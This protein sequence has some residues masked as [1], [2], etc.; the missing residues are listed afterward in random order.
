M[1][2]VLRF[3]KY[4]LLRAVLQ[5]QKQKPQLEWLYCLVACCRHVAFLYLLMKSAMFG[6]VAGLLL[7]LEKSSPAKGPP[8]FLMAISALK[9][10]IFAATSGQVGSLLHSLATALPSVRVAGLN[11]HVPTQRH[12]V[13]NVF[14]A[15]P[16]GKPEKCSDDDDGHHNSNHMFQAGTRLLGLLFVSVESGHGPLLALVNECGR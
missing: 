7:T 8:R 15:F 6:S 9:A 5:G 16:S 1:K 3:C 13:V 2:H 12:G 10:S 4:H 14:M 11:P